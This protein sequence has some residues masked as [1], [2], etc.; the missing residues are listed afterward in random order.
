MV[1]GEPIGA[2]S[3]MLLGIFFDFF[4]GFFAR[5]LNV[6]SDLGVQLDSLADMVTSGLV[7]GIIMFNLIALASEG[8]GM[9]LASWS[10][11]TQGE[12]FKIVPLSIQAKG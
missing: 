6:Q 9:N 3:F 7:P 4:D 5:K 2:V 1:L 10:T 8:Q 11:L 12:E